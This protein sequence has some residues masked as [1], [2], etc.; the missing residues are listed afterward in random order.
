LNPARCLELALNTR[1]FG[2]GAKYRPY[3]SITKAKNENEHPNRLD[4]RA[5]RNELPRVLIYDEQRKY[6]RAE[7]ND[8]ICQDGVGPTYP[9]RM[10]HVSK[11]DGD[12]DQ[13]QHVVRRG[14][15]AR[16][17]QCKIDEDR[18]NCERYHPAGRP[19]P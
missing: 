13:H 11:C 19:S 7:Y 17:S 14:G 8:P 1:K 12:E 5:I 16:S 4:V 2:L 18:R 9:G 6:R 3:D 15:S 10:G